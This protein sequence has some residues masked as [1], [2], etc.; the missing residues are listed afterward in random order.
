[1]APHHAR[2]LL[3]AL[4]LGA[5]VTVSGCTAGS[6]SSSN[7]PATVDG[8]GS[9]S[10]SKSGSDSG[11]AASPRPSDD[12]SAPKGTGAQGSKD[13]GRAPSG[14]RW[15]TTKSLSVS[16]RP[17][18]PAA[19]NRYAALVLT[20]SSSSA[21]RTQG[22]PGLQLTSESGGKIP[23]DVVRERDVPSRPLT[24]SPGG[25][26]SARLHWTVVPGKDDPSDGRC[27]DPHTVRVIPPD[28]RASTSAAWKAGEVC[29]AGEIDVRP[30][31]P[32]ADLPE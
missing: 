5:A 16:L 25:H 27:P 28:Q 17:G 9:G 11:S 19:G 14:V 22:W 26:A 29:G 10:H 1:M 15:C 24:L 30:L 21:C 8:S 3:A 20:N 12:G 23:T 7:S 2:S 32:G 4:A 13:D 6:D 31:L 18:Q